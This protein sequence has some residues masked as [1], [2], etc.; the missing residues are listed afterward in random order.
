MQGV[1]CY[2]TRPPLTCISKEANGVKNKH[3]EVMR[4]W[5]IYH[6]KHP[7]YGNNEECCLTY[8]PSQA[9]LLI[10]CFSTKIERRDCKHHQDTIWAVQYSFE[11]KGHVPTIGWTYTPLQVVTSRTEWKS[12][13]LE[14][15][16][17]PSLQNAFICVQEYITVLKRKKWMRYTLHHQSKYSHKLSQYVASWFSTWAGLMLSIGLSKARNRSSQKLSSSYWMLLP[18]Q[19]LLSKLSPAWDML[20]AFP[21]VHEGNNAE[22]TSSVCL[23]NTTTHEIAPKYEEPDGC[24]H[25]FWHKLLC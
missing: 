13:F 15:L 2:Y 14:W 24:D 12:W 18:P 8:L 19:S 6:C 16:G 11:T 5:I 9:L 1:C 17:S 21:M 20:L 22:C 3:L 23:N 4:H 10:T 7:P 25:R